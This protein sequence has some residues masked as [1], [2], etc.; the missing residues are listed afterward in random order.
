MR[1]HT[2]AFHIMLV[3]SHQ[4]VTDFDLV[5]RYCTVDVPSVGS[6]ADHVLVNDTT[7][8]NSRL[9]V[10]LVFVNLFVWCYLF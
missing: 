6:N 8:L 1:K 3:Q 9:S 2:L 10:R 5:R 7:F 4:A